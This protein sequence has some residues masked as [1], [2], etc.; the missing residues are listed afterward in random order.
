MSA[1]LR[2]TSDSRLDDPLDELEARIARARQTPPTAAEPASAPAGDDPLERL[3]RQMARAR[4]AGSLAEPPLGRLHE[5]IRRA[6]DLATPLEGYPDEGSEGGEPL[7]RLQSAIASEIEAL[8]GRPTL[9]LP[10]HRTDG[11]RPTT[12]RK[13]QAGSPA[14][15]EAEAAVG[16]ELLAL[17]DERPLAG[18]SRAEA[19]RRLADLSARPGVEHEVRAELRD[20]LELLI[21]E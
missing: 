10:R 7:E 13:G 12:V 21:F 3:E 5:A 4:A 15:P 16:R 20:I 18:S 6:Q 14:P 2:Q 1:A 11:H 9:P 17:L 8:G 19:V